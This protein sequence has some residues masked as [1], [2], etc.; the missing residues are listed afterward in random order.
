MTEVPKE[1]EEDPIAKR[2]KDLVSRTD[3]KDIYWFDDKK[4]FVVDER[5]GNYVTGRYVDGFVVIKKTFNLEEIAKMNPEVAHPQQILLQYGNR[6][7][8]SR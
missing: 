8:V 2:L 1:K 3:V 4:H 5:E 6:K 7:S